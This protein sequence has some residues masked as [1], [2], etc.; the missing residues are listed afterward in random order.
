MHRLQAVSLLSI[1]S[2]DRQ[3]S[4]EQCCHRDLE[5]LGRHHLAAEE[6]H[7]PPPGIGRPVSI[8][9]RNRQQILGIQNKL[10][11][12]F[13]NESYLKELHSL[14]FYVFKSNPSRAERA[15]CYIP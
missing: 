7:I 10:P 15:G 8:R 1:C 6:S 14:S 4:E 13:T 3:R 11:T 2:G 9:P 5:R 12:D